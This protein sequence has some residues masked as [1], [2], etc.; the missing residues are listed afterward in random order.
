MDWLVKLG[1]HEFEIW[2]E[3]KY[4]MM[5]KKC[6]YYGAKQFW[7]TIRKLGDHTESKKYKWE[8]GEIVPYYE[9]EHAQRF[10]VITEL[11][12]Y[13]GTLSFK[14]FDVANRLP[15]LFPVSKLAL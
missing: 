3:S 15:V 7:Q 1:R 13:K 11:L 6:E 2:T 8:P 5:V 10:A 4:S 12:N 14:G 9:S